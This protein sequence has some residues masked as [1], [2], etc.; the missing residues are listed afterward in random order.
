MDGSTGGGAALQQE[1]ATLHHELSKVMRTFGRQCRGKRK[2]F[3]TWVRH[4]ERQL[5]QV[6]EAWVPLALSAQL[7]LHEIEALS[8]AQKARLERRL[9]DAV[10]AHQRIEAQSRRLV[11]G[12]GLLHC[13][14]VNPYD[15]TI[16]P[17]SKGKSNC[18]TQF[19]KKP[20]LIAEMASGFIFGF[21][22]PSGNPTD[23]S[24]VLPLLGKVDNAL[25]QRDGPPPRHWLA[26]GGSGP[27]SGRRASPTASPRHPDRRH[28]GNNGPSPPK[29]D[30][31]TNPTGATDPRPEGHAQCHPDP[32]CLCLRIQSTLGGKP[33][34]ESGLPGRNPHQI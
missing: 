10:E 18:P 20:G 8:A 4:T 16:A 22:L 32:H 11:H 7:Y 29:T 5:L 1:S 19:G 33:D 6:G 17:I 26:G 31:R 13:K 25:D 24:Y 34:C 3:V 23:A 9:E 28:P 14:I 2:V 15:Q 27:E 21:H 12:K 30:A